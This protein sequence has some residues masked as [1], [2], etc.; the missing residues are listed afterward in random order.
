M[1]Y[2]P[3]N[4]S[5]TSKSPPPTSLIPARPP[6]PASRRLPADLRYHHYT[7]RVVVGMVTSVLGR[8]RKGSIGIRRHDFSW[9]QSDGIGR[10]LR[11]RRSRHRSHGGLHCGRG[12][13]YLRC[14]RQR[15]PQGMH[16]Y[17][18]SIV[19]IIAVFFWQYA[20]SVGFACRIKNRLMYVCLPWRR[21]FLRF[22][23]S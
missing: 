5:L 9:Q 16:S 11:L 12:V 7:P 2:E 13:P 21:I 18:C 4:A 6:H 3:H 15:R 10:L 14:S 20:E 17:M 23:F 8:Q 19:A 1:I 22:T